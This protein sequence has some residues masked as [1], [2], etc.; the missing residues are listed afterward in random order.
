MNWDDCCSSLA[1][2]VEKYLGDFLETHKF[3]PLLKKTL[4]HFCG[5]L[6]FSKMTHGK[7]LLGDIFGV[8]IIYLSRLLHD[9]FKTSSGLVCKTSARRLQD[10]FARCALEDKKYYTEDVLKTYSTRLQHVL[11]K[12][13]VCWVKTVCISRLAS[14]ANNPFAK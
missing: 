7:V 12:T 3:L 2:Q 1:Y 4:K 9:L 13:N 5:I 10:M 8:T 11:G 6:L 14:H